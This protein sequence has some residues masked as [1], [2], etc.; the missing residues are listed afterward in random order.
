MTLYED[1]SRKI[2]GFVYKYEAFIK[3][4]RLLKDFSREVQGCFR[5][6]RLL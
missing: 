1:I 6:V 3:I 2:E 5:N 4:T